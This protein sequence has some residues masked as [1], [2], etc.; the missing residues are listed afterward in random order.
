MRPQPRA[1]FEKPC[2]PQLIELIGSY[3]GKLQKGFYIN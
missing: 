3:G 2:V 1:V